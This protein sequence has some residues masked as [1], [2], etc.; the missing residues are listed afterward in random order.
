MTTSHSFLVERQD[1]TN[2]IDMDS[3]EAAGQFRYEGFHY[4][5]R[6]AMLVEDH[7]S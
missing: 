2:L 1:V 5:Y 4:S 3:R 7:K 6:K